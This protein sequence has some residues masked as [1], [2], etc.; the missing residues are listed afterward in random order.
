MSID[1]KIDVIIITGFLGSGKTTFINH[2]LTDNRDKLFALVENEFGEVA[3]DSQL[4]RGV[5]A[6]QMFELK[7]GC[8]CCTITDEYEQALIELADRFG[9]A[10]C[11]LIETSGIA[12]PAPVI[13]PFYENNEIKVRYNLVQTV[14]LVDAKNFHRYPAKRTALKQIAVADMVIITKA[15]EFDKDK[16]DQFCNEIRILNP[17]AG[18][19]VSSYGSVSGFN[20]YSENR[21][22]KFTPDFSSEGTP[23]HLL[24][25]KSYRF[26]Y[27]FIKDD[28]TE[29]LTYNLDLFKNEIYR[30]K[31][32]LN[33]QNDAY[34]S[35][36]QGVG[37]SFELTE[38]DILNLG[39]ESLI[40]MI[41]NLTE[42]NFQFQ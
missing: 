11:L 16:T 32:I 26:K 24:I 41:G 12:D 21:T 29:R 20:L 33:F 22:I 38:S 5:N 6:S 13:R 25:T 14:C 42:V 39:Q 4:I 30:I 27:P 23:N 1:K 28:F 36:L 34:L 40:V 19:L 31:G 18:Q 7:N 15:E 35:V 3:I 9:E 17:L 10:D 37:G 2:I 8:I